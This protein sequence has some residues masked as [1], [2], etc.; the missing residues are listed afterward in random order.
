MRSSRITHRAGSR[1]QSSSRVNR[2]RRALI[3][4]SLLAVVGTACA[5]APPVAE[6][7]A[8]AGAA[9]SR[10]L[11]YMYK[12]GHPMSL[13]GGSCTGSFAVRGTDGMFFLTA[14]HCGQVGQAVRGTDAQFGVFAHER[15]VREDTALV[16]PLRGV[17]AQQ[18][19]TNPRNGALIGSTVGWYRNSEIGGGMPVG[20]TGITTGYTEGRVE[21]WTYRWDNFTVR[22][23]TYA[24]RPGDSG[25]PISI[26]TNTS[27]LWAVGVHVGRVTLSDGSTRGCFVPIETLL[28]YWGAWLPV[29]GSTANKPWLPPAQRAESLA[30]LSSPTIV[31]A[32]PD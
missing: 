14:G 9:T 5:P 22:C 12:P 16:R 19:V 30:I 2:W 29:F 11:S 23:A 20:K 1:S 13:P 27:N 21:P 18:Q 17:D 8:L 6:R 32:V 7:T 3:A 24:S 10:S 25:G 28:G 26:R 15:N 4:A 31:R